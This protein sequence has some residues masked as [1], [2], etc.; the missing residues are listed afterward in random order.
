[1]SKVIVV[2][3]DSL[4]YIAGCLE[5]RYVGY[6]SD[7]VIISMR[8]EEAFD[9]QMVNEEFSGNDIYATGK[10]KSYPPL[11][12]Q[13]QKLDTKL[14]YIKRMTKA[15][16]LEIWLS[17]R[18]QALKDNFRLGVASIQPY[19]GN[20]MFYIKSP[21]DNDLHEYL[22]D[23]WDAKEA[24][25]EEADDVCGI[26]ATEGKLVACIDKDVVFG[27][28]GKKFNYNSG[29]FIDITLDESWFNFFKQVL[30]GD[31]GDNIPGLYR[32]ADKTADKLLS[33]C[34]SREPQD[35][36]NRVVEI[37]REYLKGEHPKRV[38]KIIHENA[39][40]LWIRRQ[41]GDNYSDYVEVV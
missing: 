41:E 19:K 20:R 38:A 27:V 36:Y 39:T 15:D 22:M 34:K 4:K 9:I 31:S 7:G 2:D 28:P 35:L 23:K 10:E 14:K 29:E 18:R 13:F 37:Y 8:D 1:M 17:P 11:N 3:G 25:G 40:L 5:T 12:F 26:A 30:T 32:V 16:S 33:K 24:V 21:Y 6:R